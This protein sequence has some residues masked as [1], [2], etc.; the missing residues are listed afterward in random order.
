VP[1]AAAPRYRTLTVPAEAYTDTLT[2]T[3]CPGEPS[4][5]TLTRAVAAQLAERV[6]LR[7]ASINDRRGTTGRLGF[8]SLAREPRA[9]RLCWTRDRFAV[10]LDDDGW[11]L[12]VVDLY[13]LAP[14]LARLR[15]QSGG[16]V[17]ALAER[18]QVAQ[19]LAAGLIKST[20]TDRICFEPRDCAGCGR[21]DVYRVR[22]RDSLCPRCRGEKP[23]D[24]IP[25]RTL[26][27]AHQ[28]FALA[29]FLAACHPRRYAEL[30]RADQC[31]QLDL[32][33]DVGDGQP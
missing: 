32:F 7:T 15:T 16:R 26:A 13:E 14:T 31:L 21:R 12:H 30:A 25:V 10:L 28:H 22:H 5:W 3:H 23:A 17:L 29:E 6:T 24:P 19:R 18:H 33:L 9:V 20:A 11:D 8:V 4:T 1:G 2:P 27:E